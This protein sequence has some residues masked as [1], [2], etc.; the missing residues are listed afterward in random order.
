MGDGEEFK[1]SSRNRQTAIL[2]PFKGGNSSRVDPQ[3]SS[4]AAKISYFSGELW[5]VD[6]GLCSMSAALATLRLRYRTMTFY[7]A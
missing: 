6:C 5:T 7:C 1:T 4:Y 3:R 2:P